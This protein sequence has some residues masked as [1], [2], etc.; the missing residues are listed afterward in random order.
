MVSLLSKSDIQALNID[1][2]ERAI[3]FSSTVL[4]ASLVGTDIISMT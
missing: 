3:V 4:R 2:V 1:T